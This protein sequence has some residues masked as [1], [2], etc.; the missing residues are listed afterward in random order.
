MTEGQHISEEDLALYA[1]SALS[2][3]EAAGVQGHL[4]AC[5][6]CGELLAELNGDLALLAL[7]V[8]QQ[9]LPAGA[10]DRF[11]S[12]IQADAVAPASGVTAVPAA[13]V[14]PATA[15]KPIPFPSTVVPVSSARKPSS[16][17][18][19]L[20]WLLAAAAL[21]GTAYL[22]SEVAQLRTSRDD[23][24]Y[25]VA[26]LAAASARAQEVF[27]TL[28]SP[29]AQ[30]VT[31]TEGKPAA[32]PTGRT[33][34]LPSRGALVFVANNLRPIPASKAYELWVI[35]ANGKAPIPAGTFR[36]DEHGTASVVLP[37][38]PLGVEAKAFGVTIEQAEGSP[39]PTLP[40]VL[41]G[42]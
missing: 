5:A 6:A 17:T 27:E 8:D 23:A 42:S 10:G 36:P 41:S 20:P 25:Q 12:R 2:P 21:A 22:G 31:L 35:P 14:A 40:I 32:A 3:A 34:Y 13:Q 28:T 38:L 4:S 1:M 7:S 24:R 26:K 18:V 39:T 16:G 37:K 15:A 9:E 19:V 11:L 30:Q 29:Q 33:S